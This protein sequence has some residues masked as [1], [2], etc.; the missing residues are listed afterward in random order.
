MGGSAKYFKEFSFVPIQL[1]VAFMGTSS[2]PLLGHNTLPLVKLDIM[3]GMRNPHGILGWIDFHVATLI[4]N[5][6]YSWLFYCQKRKH[7]KLCRT[8]DFTMVDLRGNKLSQIWK[9]TP[10]VLKDFDNIWHVKGLIIT[11]GNLVVTWKV[12]PRMNITSYVPLFTFPFT[13]EFAFKL[14]Q[15]EKEKEKEII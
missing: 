2:I 15:K 7:T 11:H 12:K 8:P 3:L 9:K 1:N 14:C 4:P 6:I 10:N 5:S 13:L